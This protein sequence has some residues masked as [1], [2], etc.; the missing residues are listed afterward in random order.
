[1]T[2]SFLIRKEITKPLAGLYIL[3]QLAGAMAGV[4]LAHLMFDLAPLTMSSTERTGSGQWIGEVVASFGLVMTILGCLRFNPKALP[5]AVGL[6]ISAGYW[7]TSS[8][9][10]ANPA[11]TLGRAFTDT[12][13]GIGPMDAPWFIVAQLFGAAL[14]TVC[15]R[16][17][18]SGG[19]P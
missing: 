18:F 6:F 3:V 8:T 16:W 12:F 2:L 7:F 19:R 11:V 4:M 14:A 10:F 13:S 9:S 1:V 15:A 5:M 17:L